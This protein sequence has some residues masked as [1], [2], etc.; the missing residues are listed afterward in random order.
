MLKPTIFLFRHL[1]E[2]LPPL[3]SKERT[4][5][6]KHSL[7]HLENDPSVS[8]CAAEDA[9]IKFG[10]E[11]WPWN[12]AY[13]EFSNIAEGEMGEHFLLSLLSPELQEKYL[14][15]KE[16]GMGLGEFYS[17]RTAEY[18]TL[19]ERLELWPAMEKMRRHLREY[20][21]R[22]IISLSQRQY[23]EKVDEFNLLLEKI[24]EQLGALRSLADREESH[25][26][27]VEEINTKI[28]GFEESLCG[29]GPEMH[30][31]TLFQSVEF[32]EERKI[33][34]NRLRGVHLSKKIN[35]YNKDLPC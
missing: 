31:P 25:P 33:H 30:L 23:L 27:L 26:S 15:Y 32:F 13:K 12:Q 2:N 10:Y 18:F 17:G 34:L 14:E 22:E 8:A 24:K 5:E 1:Y 6:I 3:F 29:L 19:E 7:A 11:V 21:N 4:A 9:L 16:Y 28:R 20:V 35:F